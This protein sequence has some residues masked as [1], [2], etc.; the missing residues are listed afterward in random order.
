MIDAAP[1]IRRVTWQP[2]RVPFRRPFVTSTGAVESR[3]GVLIRL[4]TDMGETGIGE[5][6]PLPHYNGG[7]LA[8]ALDSV[9]TVARGLAGRT[10]RELWDAGVDLLPLSPGTAAAVRCGFET[11]LADL[12]AR[13]T[14]L[15]L[16][17][18]LATEAGL[19]AFPRI[20]VNGTIDAADP[21]AAAEEARRLVALGFET[22]KVKAGTGDAE[23]VERLRAVREVAGDSVELRIDANGAWSAEHAVEILQQLARFGVAL[24]EQPTAAGGPG[25]FAAL[26]HVRAKSSV[27]IAADES[28]RTASDVQQLIAAGAVETIVVKPMAAGLKASLEMMSAAR[29]AGLSVIVTTMLDAGPG[30]ALAMHV[31]ARAGDPPPACGLATLD[32][33]AGTLACGVPSAENG[34][35]MLGTGHG[36]GITIDEDELERFAAGP[37]GEA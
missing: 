25:Q 11:A 29:A 34:E 27:A 20:P 21:E 18:W 26:A 16:Y 36:L 23:D 5:C 17:R 3:E 4:E 8:E 13:E 19:T 24:C 7:S 1:R 28:C 14:Q 12:L 22:L 32:L 9:E 37:R 35:V 30:T 2:F 33:L 10:T 31:A 15:P 6:S